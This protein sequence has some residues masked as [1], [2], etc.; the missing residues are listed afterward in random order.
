MRWQSW[1]VLVLLLCGGSWIIYKGLGARLPQADLR[2]GNMSEPQTLDPASMTGSPEG[3]IAR[4]LFDGLTLPN[5]ND[6]TRPLPGSAMS[7]KVSPDG[8]VYTF[9]IRENARWSNGAPVTADHFLFSWRRLLSPSIGSQYAELLW[10]VSNAQA[11]NQQLFGIATKT[12]S[13]RQSPSNKAAI[14]SKVSK[15]VILIRRDL[16]QKQ[17]QSKT[18][19]LLQNVDGK[20]VKGAVLSAGMLVDVLHKVEIGA[21]V[22]YRVRHRAKGEAV[23]G[24]LRSD[25]L[26]QRSK[27]IKAKKVEWWEVS[28]MKQKKVKGWVKRTSLGALDYTFPAK[29]KSKRLA[30]WKLVG[31]RALKVTKPLPKGYS[32]KALGRSLVF[33]VTLE[34]PTAYFDQLASFYSLSPVYP[35]LVKRYPRSWVLPRHFVG[36]GPFK[37][38]HWM[39]NELVRVE[40]NPYYWNAKNMK[41]GS[42]HFMAVSERDTQL[43]MYLSRDLDIVTSVPLPS[44]D[45]LL[46]R[47]D[48]FSRLYLATYFYRFNVNVPP[49]NNKYVRQALAYAVNRESIT[50]HI[51]R[52]GQIPAF[53]LVPPGIQ[54]YPLK[55]AP[56]PKFNPKK[57]RALLRKAGYQSGA[58]IP[59]ISLLYNTDQQHKQVAEA[60]QTMWQKHLGIRVHLV[61]KEWKTYLD[62][63]T[64]RNYQMARAGWIADYTDPN[65]FLSMFI[66]GGGHNRTGWSNVRYDRYIK[67]AENERDPV[68]R[69]A[70]FRHAEKILM[71][72]LPIMPL[73]F[74]NYQN[75]IHPSIKG[76]VNNPLN[77]FDYRRLARVLNG[78]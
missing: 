4:A 51:L 34:N 45:K 7:W 50:K 2:F 30:A 33:E 63:V 77:I 64:Q 57:A 19:T 5:L 21:A 76:H 56:G 37:M 26:F 22:W 61:N 66:T 47:K 59:P 60:L 53:R 41:L 20:P 31:M 78:K 15:G 46:K 43:S 13:L 40:K 72:E 1:L 67:L 16:G 3:R 6:L 58:A 12:L 24:W 8:K 32:V 49:L 27:K 9:Y 14:V 28:L 38:T 71:D 69:M 68:K 70:H 36:N 65:T 23:E 74:Y 18:V 11:F 17:I 39:I 73:Y 29:S 48:F 44:I 52:A 62:A 42:I 10:S 25:S 54:G 55:G 75:L 35:P